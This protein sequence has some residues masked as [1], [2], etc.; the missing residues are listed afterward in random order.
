MLMLAV[1]LTVAGPASADTERLH[2]K[3]GARA[4]AVAVTRPSFELGQRVFFE[5]TFDGNGRTCATCHE[6]RSEFTI[7]PRLVQD[8]FAADPGHPLF[9]PIDSDDGDG[10]SYSIMLANAVFRVK[11]PLHDDVILLDDP[12]RRTVKLWRGVPS[13]S[14]VALTAPYLQDGRATSLQSQARGAIRDHMQPARRQFSREAEALKTFLFELYNPLSV[15]ALALAGDPIP[16]SAGFTLPIESETGLRGK[17][18]FDLHCRRCHGGELGSTAEDPTVGQFTDVFVSDANVPNLP[19]MRFG[20]RQTDGSI[21]EIVTPDPGRGALTG[22][23]EDVNAFDIPPL[24]GVK[25]TS[26]YFH[27]NSAATLR[28][29]IEHYNSEFNFGIVGDEIEDLIVYLELL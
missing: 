9:R 18:T 24:R 25:S 29:V 7:T 3:A 27:D 20:F 2:A 5:E 8:R 26:P 16:L 15:R 19:L 13:I 28:E 12:G 22:R 6:P 1:G 21:V 10:A 11:I 14:N 23:L 4:A 17:A